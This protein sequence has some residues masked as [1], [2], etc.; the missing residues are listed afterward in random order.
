VLKVVGS[1]RRWWRVCPGTTWVAS[2]LHAR[3]M[4]VRE[5]QRH[6]VELLIDVSSV[7]PARTSTVIED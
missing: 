1:L 6:V 7:S 3:G 2:G 5:I 4:T